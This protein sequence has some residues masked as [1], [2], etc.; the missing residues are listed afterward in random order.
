[1]KVSCNVIKDLLPLYIENLTSTDSRELVEEHLSSC[2]ACNEEYEKLGKKN[3]IEVNDNLQP[4]I[5]LKKMLQR[6]K[7]FTIL[8]AVT[9]T[10]ACVMIAIGY[11]TSP[12]YIPYSEE[13]VN[14]I[15]VN[16]NTIRLCFNGEIDGYDIN[17]DYTE[18]GVDY[19]ITIWKTVLGRRLRSE[20]LSN[21]IINPDGEKVDHIFYVQ[22]NGEED[23][24]I[25][26]V[27]Q[28]DNG[29]R[30]TLPRLALSMYLLL[31]VVSIIICSLLWILFRKEKKASAVITNIELF[32]IAYLIGHLCLK[33][34]TTT[35]YS[36]IH[37]FYTILLVTIPIY[38]VLLFGKKML[39]QSRILKDHRRKRGTDIS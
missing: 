9:I 32:P 33:G 26:G 16:D 19:S 37:D 13:V 30:I 1:M 4:L 8:F 12:K 11:L 28:F 18:D 14:V 17:K 24:L 31:A 6:K 15:K 3:D 39:V 7:M 2:L 20:E 22:N 29:G 10:L 5:K 21:I 27:N 34:V 23:I 36:I 25:Y 38:C 35:S